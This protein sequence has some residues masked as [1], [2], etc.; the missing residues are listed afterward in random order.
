MPP[1][2]KDKRRRF[3]PPPPPPHR[4]LPVRQRSFWAGIAVG[5]VASAFIVTTA[6]LRHSSSATKGPWGTH[7]ADLRERL[8]ALG[9]AALG[10]EG[11]KLHT[12]QHLDVYVNGK[13]IAIPPN[14]GIGPHGSFYS[15]LH[16]HDT[17]GIIHL[18]SATVRSYTLG[19]FFR[20]WGVRLT[21]R[22]IDG[23][24][25][26]LDAF[27]D[28]RRVVRNPGDIRLTQ[29]EEIA[30]VFGRRPQQIPSHYSFPGGV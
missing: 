22:C 1:A 13:H 14:I 18:E 8:R 5:L 10:S 6:V 28:G 21:A 4:R 19:E 25:G 2:R 15:P 9:F 29:H 26:K 27:V 17:S 11:T 30:L 20:V 7:T 24:C 16:T 23:H 12:H 3:A